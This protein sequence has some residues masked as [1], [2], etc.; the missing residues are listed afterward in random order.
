M[1]KGVKTDIDLYQ[2]IVFTFFT[3]FYNILYNIL[4]SFNIYHNIL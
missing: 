4:Y 3:F 1:R 2:F